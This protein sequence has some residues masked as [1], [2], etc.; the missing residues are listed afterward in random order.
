MAREPASGEREVHARSWQGGIANVAQSHIPS[1]PPPLG[2]A[3][4]FKQPEKSSGL[5][6]LA[7]LQGQS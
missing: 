7:L 3:P 5:Q 2:T 4:G 1:P 6:W